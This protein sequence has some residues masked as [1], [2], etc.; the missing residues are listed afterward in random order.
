MGAVNNAVF[1][2]ASDDNGV[3][4]AACRRGVAK[5]SGDN[6]QMLTDDRLSET[7]N[8]EVHRGTGNIIVTT[9]FG[10]YVSKD[11]GNTWLLPDQRLKFGP[12]PLAQFSDG[13]L[14]VGAGKGVFTSGNGGILWDS[15]SP[16]LL[17]S[18]SAGLLITRS[19]KIFAG[20]SSGIIASTDKGKN[21]V[22]VP[23]IGWYTSSIEENKQTGAIF[24]GVTSALAT[25]TT[26]KIFRSSNSGATWEVVNP[27]KGRGIDAIF[28]DEEGTLYAGLSEVYRS[29]DNGTTWEQ[30][31]ENTPQGPQM[32][33]FCRVGN[34]L[35]AGDRARGI[36][37][38]ELPT[39]STEKNP[40][41]KNQ[42]ELLQNYPNPFNPATT[43]SYSLQ[44][45]AEVNLAIYNV[46]GEKVAQLVVG[47]M[48]AG[49]HTVEWNAGNLPSGLYFCRML[50]NG[51]SDTKKL[52]LLK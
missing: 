16:R 7:A 1:D 14:L 48:A 40:V 28:A 49:E 24:V 5:I 37:A 15:I 6:L 36:F 46:S 26:A 12:F 18:A 3:V 32:E 31:G 11:G 34:T 39:T 27:Q 44:Q 38:L 41:H 20:V 45:Q 21:W 19:E 4:Y 50:S 22:E 25:S 29:L 47:V 2:F 17:G 42:F 13:T 35:Y 51:F 8:I 30:F 52:I 23:G 10:L 33:A 9:M 43:I